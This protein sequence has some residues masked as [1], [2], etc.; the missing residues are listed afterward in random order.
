[1]KVRNGSPEE[2]DF[3]GSCKDE[4]DGL[5]RDGTYVEV[6]Y[7]NMIREPRIFG[8]RIF[9]ELKRVVKHLR[10]KSRLVAHDSAGEGASTIATKA[11][12]VQRFIQR[13]SLCLAASTPEMMTYTGYVT[14]PYIQSHTPLERDVYIRA[15]S[16]MRLE[17]ECVLK[18]FRPLYRVY[19]SGMH[20]FLTYLAHHLEDL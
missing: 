7:N 9:D 8:S 3:A 19:D 17:T 12:I 1:M 5:L 15:P 16:E 13:L 2:R 10:R 11:P 18:G 6:Q 14:Q 20:W 4:I